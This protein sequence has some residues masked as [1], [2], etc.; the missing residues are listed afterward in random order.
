LGL[1]DRCFWVL[2]STARTPRVA[3]EALSG[4]DNQ[5]QVVHH[6]SQDGRGRGSAYYEL[7]WEIPQ[8]YAQPLFITPFSVEA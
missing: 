5:M 1:G 8:H 6:W 4:L 7:K 3:R 2:E